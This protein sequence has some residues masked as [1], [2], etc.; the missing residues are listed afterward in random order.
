MTSQQ[1]DTFSYAVPYLSNRGW[2]EIWNESSCG[3]GEWM[4]S[5]H[6]VISGEGL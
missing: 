2:Y 5:M 3:F 1:S 4:G 6:G